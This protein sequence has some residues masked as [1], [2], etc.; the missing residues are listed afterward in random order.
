MA[1]AL[2]CQLLS[3][4]FLVGICMFYC[5]FYCVFSLSLTLYLFLCF[6]ILHASCGECCGCFLALVTV[7]SFS[8]LPLL[9]NLLFWSWFLYYSLYILIGFLLGRNW[10]VDVGES[11]SAR[12]ASWGE[13]T[14]LGF[15]AT[16][17]IM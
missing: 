7:P 1:F 6:Y 12:C 2:F 4:Y 13:S 11:L 5:C 14:R 8:L 16:L 9:R 3:R 15:V 17:C 10:E